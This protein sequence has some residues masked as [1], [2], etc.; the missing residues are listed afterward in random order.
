ML[1]AAA[2]QERAT[3][4]EQAPGQVQMAPRDEA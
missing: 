2:V 1:E 4:P 3:V